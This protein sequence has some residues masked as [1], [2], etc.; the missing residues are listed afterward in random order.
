MATIASLTQGLLD[1]NGMLMAFLFAEQR[2]ALTHADRA[3]LRN[4]GAV[5]LAGNVSGRGSDTVR[6]RRI[7]L[8]HALPMT[9][10]ASET[11]DVAPSNVTVETGDVVVA[12]HAL[13]ISESFFAQVVD[14]TGQL[15]PASLAE[16]ALDSYDAGW[17]ADLATAGATFSTAVGSNSVANS[18]DDLLDLQEEFDEAA[19]DGTIYLMVHGTQVSNIRRSASQEGGALKERA[20]IQNLMARKQQGYQGDILGFEV[21]RSNRVVSSSGG[22]QGF[23]WSPGAIKSAMGTTERITTVN[24]IA[25]PAGTPLII[26]LDETHASTS[27]ELAFNGFWGISVVNAALG[28]LFRG[29]A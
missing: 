8:G 4:T 18:M 21:W 7:G 22:R 13:V 26:G 14:D 9:A 12:R 29:L 15:N 16:T 19:V 28:R 20:D 24:G 23:A 6:D 3:S 5:I 25:R 1:T 27:Q 17:M 10:T 2:I 11:E